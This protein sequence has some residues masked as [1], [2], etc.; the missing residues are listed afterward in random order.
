MAQ[1]LV[2]WDAYFLTEGREHYPLA[3]DLHY[4][5]MTEDID[6][7]S[8]SCINKLGNSKRMTRL[9][10][11]LS[12]LFSNFAELYDD[13][14]VDLLNVKTLGRDV[15]QNYNIVK[16][17]SYYYFLAGFLYTDASVFDEEEC[18]NYLLAHCGFKAEGINP[19]LIKELSPYKLKHASNK[20]LRYSS[21]NW[22]LCYGLKQACSVYEA[23]KAQNLGIKEL[24]DILFN[25]KKIEAEC[26]ISH[27]DCIDVNPYR[28]TDD[29]LADSRWKMM[30]LLPKTNAHYSVRYRTKWFNKRAKILEA[31]ERGALGNARLVLGD[32]I[33]GRRT[34]KYK[35]RDDFL[36]KTGV[37]PWTFKKY[38]GLISKSSN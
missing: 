6:S 26:K 38:V 3:E 13:F 31:G 23:Y 4:R 27:S 30:V 10:H 5:L 33:K 35:D 8:S 12:R 37:N 34:F 24:S 36:L 17:R 16:S 32:Y 11:D 28:N 19:W 22:A 20:F 7:L 9:F 29:A 1:S 21:T 18:I 2:G 14:G 25:Y 15:L